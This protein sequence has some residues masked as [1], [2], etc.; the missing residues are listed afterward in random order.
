MVDMAADSGL[1]SGRSGGGTAVVTPD[2]AGLDR[3]WVRIACAGRLY[4]IPLKRVREILAPQ[5]LTRLPGCDASVAGLLG[6]RGRIVTVLDLGRTLGAAPSVAVPD[7]R[8]LLVEAGER[9][10]GI[11]VDD[12]KGVADGVLS[13]TAPGEDAG[14][15]CDGNATVCG[16]VVA[17]NEGFPA[18]DLDA[19]IDRH[20]A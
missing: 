13:T 9:V 19:V 14:I 15:D 2:D 4:C 17:G 20:F 18:L 11:I 16:R 1:T 12:A 7:H 10:V 3:R 6:V 8:V 5:P